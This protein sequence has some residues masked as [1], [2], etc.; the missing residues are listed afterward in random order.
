MPQP[1][2]VV[3]VG[4]RGEMVDDVD[5][6]GHGYDEMGKNMGESKAEG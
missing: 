3:R 1:E 4:A 2:G 5:Y 6:R